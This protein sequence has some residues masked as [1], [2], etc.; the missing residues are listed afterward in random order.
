VT[1]R[2]IPYN[3]T[4]ADDGQIVRFL[5]GKEAWYALEKLRYRRVK[6]KLLR[7]L[8]RFIGDSFILFRNP[9][10]YQDL[11]DNSR[12]RHHFLCTAK[13]DLATVNAHLTADPDEQA[14][15]AACRSFLAELEIA[16]LSIREKRR[17]IYRTLGAIVGENNVCFDPFSLISHATDATDWRLYLPLAVV[18]P[19]EAAQIS[20]LLKAIA[21][22]KL[23]VIPRGGGTG[24]TGGSVP[25]GADCIV[26]NVEKLNRIHG[27]F[28]TDIVYPDGSIQKTAVMRLEA[29]VITEQAISLAARNGLVF[30]TDPTSAWASSIGGNIAE[31][32][33]GK[34]AV[35]WGTAIDNLLSY[36]IT[37]AQGQEWTVRRMHHPLRKILPEDTVLFEIRDSHDSRVGRVS[38]DASEIR[39]PGLGKDI[40][41]KAL[42]GLPGIQKEGTDGIITSAEFVLHPAYPHQTTCCLEFFG[43]DMDEA[44]RVIVDISKAFVNQGREALMALEHFDEEYVRAIAYKVKAPRTRLPK[45]V[46]LIDIVGHTAGQVA[47][48]KDRLAALLKPYPNTCLFVARDAEEARQFWQDRKRLGAIASRTNAFKLNEDIVLPLHSLADF[49]MFVDSFNGEEDRYNQKTVVWQI[50]AVLEELEATE[51]LQWLNDRLARARELCRQAIDLLEFAGKDALREEK[52]LQHLIGELEGLFHGNPTV[53]SRIREQR[54]EVRRRLIIIATHMHAGDGNVHV[55]IPVFSNDRDMMIRAAETADAVMAKAV[56][57]G[58]VVSGEHGIGFT[59]LKYLDSQKL[60][61]LADYRKQVDP[62]SIMNPGKLDDLEIPEKV[63]ASSFNLLGLE[64]RI[65]KHGSLEV[66]AEKISK[67]IRC[68]RCKPDC[69]VFSPAENLFFHPR[70]KNLAIGS[71]IEAMLYDAQRSHSTRFELLHYLEEIADHCTI[72]HKCLPPCP[73]GIDTGEISILEREILETLRYKHTALATRLTLSYLESRSGAINRVMRK[74]MTWGAKVQR[75]GRRLLTA[76]DPSSVVQDFPG[77]SYLRSPV[78]P[79]SRGTL[80]DVLPVSGWNH[81]LCIEPPEPAAFTVFYFPGCGSERLFSSISIAAIYLLLKSQTRVVLPPAFLCCGYPAQVNAKSATQGRQVLQNAIIFSQ[82]REMLGYLSFDACVV[83]CGTCREA[84]HQMDMQEIFGCG[85]HDVS[86]F[87][88]KTGIKIDANET[89]LYHRPCHDSLDAQAEDLLRTCG[90]HLTPV[91]H[92]CSEA[93]TL[94]LSRPDISHAML[95]RKQR[96][97]SGIIG[98]SGQSGIKLLT[99][100]PSCLQGLGRNASVIPRHMTEELAIQIGGKDWEKEAGHLVQNAERIIF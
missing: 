14:I 1:D 59:K 93:G 85:I 96:T 98:D 30:A 76:M 66:L 61:D 92:C 87:V 22:L 68:G 2:E 27:I 57:L 34:T 79:L 4:S 43:E 71:L 7:L 26:L 17:Q 74:T 40:T 84:L 90:Y 31:N 94:S 54:T 82:I 63:F 73:V 44:S 20:P 65:L 10:I 58:G 72:C 3:Y 19:T 62:E 55:N 13:D 100:C 52:H 37:L 49:A 42:G 88:L 35:L 28:E 45:A 60:K 32:A 78:T 99:H 18:Y 77:I 8:L 9:F 89:C 75:T 15:I 6:G 97:L 39:T 51:D 5:L 95:M 50:G 53:C 47:Q 24:L 86:G 33:G 12:R 56:E 46:L 38:L 16:L 91:P 48:G 69:C 83:S 67:C 36:R 70:N 29:G 21:A 81:S 23:R 80:R 41:N 11:I 25:V 64:A